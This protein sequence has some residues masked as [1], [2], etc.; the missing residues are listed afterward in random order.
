M[1]EAKFSV[2][3]L[4]SNVCSVPALGCLG[5]QGRITER[6][7]E[8][9]SVYGSCAYTVV[10]GSIEVTMWQDELASSEVI[11]PRSY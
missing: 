7:P 9:D 6:T 11:L 8:L 2:G 5:M 1:S 10:F 4:V 3:D